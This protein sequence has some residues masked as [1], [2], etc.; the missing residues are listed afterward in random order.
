MVDLDRPHCFLNNVKYVRVHFDPNAPIYMA[1][2]NQHMY[3]INILF[4]SGAR[5]E[6][7]LQVKL[8]ADKDEVLEMLYTLDI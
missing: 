8:F 5:H 6:N 3:Y 1:R 4:E 2:R 7:D